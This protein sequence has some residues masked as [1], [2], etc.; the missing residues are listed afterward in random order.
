MRGKKNHHCCLGVRR[1]ANVNSHIELGDVRPYIFC[2]S[3]ANRT[4]GADTQG[5]L[6]AAVALSP[7]P[8]KQ[9]SAMG[10]SEEISA[11]WLKRIPSWVHPNHITFLNHVVVWALVI[12]AHATRPP[13]SST[14][15]QVIGELTVA[16]LV[17]FS[18]VLDCLD[19]M[20]ARKT[21][22]TSLRGEFLDHFL[23]T[24]HIVLLTLAVS[25]LY[26]F[27]PG[28]L[29]LNLLLNNLL[30]FMQVV[31]LYET[32]T[33][34]SVAGVGGQLVL[35]GTIVLHALLTAFSCS[36][37]T[38]FSVGLLVTVFGSCACLVEF[39]KFL[40]HLPP[41]A[42]A[43]VFVHL[44]LNLVPT[45]MLY[46]ETITSLEFGLVSGFLNLVVT[47]GYVGSYVR[48]SVHPNVSASIT[49]PLC[50][51]AILSILV[52]VA[53]TSVMVWSLIVLFAARAYCYAL[54]TCF[55]VE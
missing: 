17:Y 29:A 28:F 12:L 44:G 8:R 52:P 46:Q 21:Q 32:K 48:C 43:R 54:V 11:P 25:T 9:P 26:A 14:V 23:D 1:T 7:P 31:T 55:L 42:D 6:E 24:L 38:V 49:A 3:S 40:H 33:F 39:F 51:V 50:G 35:A 10:L 19:G 34:A 13:C 18:A 47:G 45:Y 4:K 53:W 22:R 20:W 30:Y 41:A 2:E 37:G 27:P 15:L 16:F 5:L 36:Y